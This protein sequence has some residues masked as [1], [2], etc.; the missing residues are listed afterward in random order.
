MLTYE[1]DRTT[2][3]VKRLVAIGNSI[4]LITITTCIILF[5]ALLSIPGFY[6]LQEAWWLGAILGALL[7]LG[8]GSYLA[9]LN[10]VLIEWLAQ[11]LVAQG[12]ILVELKKRRS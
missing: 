7:G 10:S 5:A 12:E 8:L 11:S 6:A 3:I 1:H 4:R 9:S 2:L